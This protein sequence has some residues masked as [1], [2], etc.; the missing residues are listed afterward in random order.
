MVMAALL[1]L[2]TSAAYQVPICKEGLYITLLVNC[3]AR[4]SEEVRRFSTGVLL[5]ICRHLGNRTRHV[6][7]FCE[8]LTL[9]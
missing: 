3:S 2:S 6:T 7:R 9:K 8:F 5:N 1:N 4:N